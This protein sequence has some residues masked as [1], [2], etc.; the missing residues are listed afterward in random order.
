MAEHDEWKDDTVRREPIRPVLV[1]I[2]FSAVSIHALTW[3]IDYAT[4]TPC[5]VHTIHVVDRR[6]H[7]G[8]LGADP[9]ALKN[10]LARVHAEAAAELKRLVDDDQRKQMLLHEHVAIGGAADEILS[11]AAD[12]NAGTIIV[13]SHGKSAIERLL[14]GSTAERLVRN[15]RCTVVVVRAPASR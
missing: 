5:E 12:I 13:G 1:A 14:L 7:R 2:D 8:D 4:R 11:V 3:A 6:L 10:E 9:T 15:A